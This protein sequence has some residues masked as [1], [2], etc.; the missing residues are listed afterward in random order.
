VVVETGG[1]GKSPII[2]GWPFLNIARAIIY[3]NSAK[4]CFNKKGKREVFLSRIEY[5]N[6]PHI[7]NTPT[8]QKRRT[9]GGTRTRIRTRSHNRRRQ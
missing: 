6:S 8:S 7:H 4:I 1:D 5:Y 9:I 3:A 2:L